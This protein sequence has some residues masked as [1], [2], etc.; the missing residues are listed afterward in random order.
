M[1]S[2]ISLRHRI[3]SRPCLSGNEG[4]TAQIVSDFLTQYNP[5][6]LWTGIAG[7]GIIARLYGDNVR[8]GQVDF[9]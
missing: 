8:Y 4:E 6:K 3:H 7:S 5:D 9:L 1:E 2:L